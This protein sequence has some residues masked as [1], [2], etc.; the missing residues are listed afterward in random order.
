[1]RRTRAWAKVVGLVLILMYYL[2]R[3]LAIT[4]VKGHDMSRGFRF[5]RKFISSAL[6]FLNVDCT[7]SGDGI[8]VP[9]LYVSNHRSLLDPFLNLYKVDAYVVSKAEVEAYPLVGRGAKETGV[10]FVQRNNSA[11]RS[12]AKDAIRV[13]LSEGKS[14]L[15]Y[16][17][18]TTSNLPTSDEFKLGSFNVAA[19]LGIPV[20]PMALDY[21]KHEHKWNDGGLFEFFINK[22]SDQKIAAAMSIGQ[23]I[24]GSDAITLKENAQNWINNE[25][26]RFSQGWETS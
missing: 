22:F 19:E 6:D 24:Y 16:P 7:F 1:M 4:S 2:S 21:R 9:A 25:L 18:G 14:I 3:L 15:I 13:A 23:P 26:I 11:S 20:V 10:I 12:A 5:R 8:E 17:E